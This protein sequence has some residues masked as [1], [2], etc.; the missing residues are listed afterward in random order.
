MANAAIALARYEC[1]ACYEPFKLCDMAITE[2]AA[3]QITADNMSDTVIS[4]DTRNIKWRV[5]AT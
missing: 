4:D 2:G 5:K 1:K 3:L